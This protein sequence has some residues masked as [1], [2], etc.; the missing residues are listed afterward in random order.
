MERARYSGCLE[1]PVL[2][3]SNDQKYKSRDLGQILGQG[4]NLFWEWFWPKREFEVDWNARGKIS[5]VKD[6][7]DCYSCWAFSTTAAIEALIAIDTNKIVDLSEQQLVECAHEYGCKQGAS[8]DTGYVYI[9]R[10]GLE[11]EKDY[12]YKPSQVVECQ[13]NK[14][15]P[16]RIRDFYSVTGDEVELRYELKEHPVSVGLCAKTFSRYSSGVFNECTNPCKRDHAVLVVGFGSQGGKDFWLIKN[17]Y[18]QNWGEKGY[19]RIQ[20]NKNNMCGVAGV[21]IA[22]VGL[23]VLDDDV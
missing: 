2:A 16:L 11:L 8:I 21:G 23:H 5:P 4:W 20:R 22:P 1:E 12:P 19:I 18:G 3:T 14:L 6:Q 9:I 15:S 13:R 17:S 7:G 10:N